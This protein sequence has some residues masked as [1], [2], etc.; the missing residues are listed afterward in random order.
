[1]ALLSSPCRGFPIYEFNNPKISPLILSTNSSSYGFSA[2]LS[3]IQY[4]REILLACVARKTT[5]V[6]QSN[7]S[8]KGELRAIINFFCHWCHVPS[9][10]EDSQAM[11]EWVR[12]KQCARVY[13]PTYNTIFQTKHWGIYSAVYS[14]VPTLW[15]HYKQLRNHVFIAFYYNPVNLRQ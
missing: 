13:T 7:S 10:T 11:F 5:S 12:Q 9:R 6:E 2:I 8:L 1:M 15:I 4:G 3:Q 14:T